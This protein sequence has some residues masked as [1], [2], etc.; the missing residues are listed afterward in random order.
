VP[1][2]CV[3]RIVCIPFSSVTANARDKGRAAETPAKHDN[4]SRRVRLSAKLDPYV[5]HGTSLCIRE[6]R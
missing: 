4:A 2:I 1:A 5:R 6:A 3:R